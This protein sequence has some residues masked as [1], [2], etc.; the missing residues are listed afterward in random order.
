MTRRDGSAFRIGDRCTCRHSDPERGC[1]CGYAD[2]LGDQDG[3]TDQEGPFGLAFGQA[4]AAGTGGWRVAWR[5]P[6]T[7]ATGHGTGTFP[8]AEAKRYAETLN[9][10]ESGKWQVFSVEPWPVAER[11]DAA[12]GAKEGTP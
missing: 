4:P 3:D 1:T 7:G 10:S 9:A 11:S 5:A 6:R 8:Y 12:E 2:W